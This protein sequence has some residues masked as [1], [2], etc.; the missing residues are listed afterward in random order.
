MNDRST[1]TGKKALIAG[2]TKGIGRAIAQEFLWLS[3]E[4]AI[5]ACHQET[6]ILYKCI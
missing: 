3:A 5:I 6:L 4:V 2:G 1:L